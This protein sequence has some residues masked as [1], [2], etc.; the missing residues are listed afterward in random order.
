MINWERIVSKLRLEVAGL[1]RQRDA[2]DKA[3]VAL[4]VVQVELEMAVNR[5]THDRDT[6]MR[7]YHNVISDGL[8]LADL[9]NEL[10]DENKR[11]MLRLG[12]GAAPDRAVVPAEFRK[13]TDASRN[14]KEQALRKA[15]SHAN[16]GGLAAPREDGK[17][18][19]GT[20][21]DER[22]D[23]TGVR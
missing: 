17:E 19:T 9:V 13:D 16:N 11:L 1:M 6:V 15:W 10:K 7:K 2:L 14:A 12:Y 18:G 22:V 20:G 23:P 8:K 21:T 5:L 3:N 4:Q